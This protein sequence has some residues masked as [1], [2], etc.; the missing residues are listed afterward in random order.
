MESV[1]TIQRISYAFAGRVVAVRVSGN[2]DPAEDGLYYLHNDQLGS[3]RMIS[4]PAGQEADGPIDYY[5]F[6]EY[7]FAPETDL[8]DRGFTGHRH[9]NMT[10]NDLG[11]IYM[12]ARYYVP[13]IGRFASADTIVPDP[14]NPQSFNRY[15]YSLNNPIYYTDPSG[16][17]QGHYDTQTG[18]ATADQEC[19]D[20]VYQEFC[21]GGSTAICAGYN[22]RLVVLPEHG[23]PNLLFFVTPYTKDELVTLRDA[24]ADAINALN[25]AGYDG[26]ALTEAIRFSH[27][28]C[29]GKSCT[30]SSHYIMLKNVTKQTIW[31]E[32]GHA[33]S[34][35]NDHMP[36]DSYWLFANIL[37]TAF[38]DSPAPY[39]LGNF[40]F[41]EYCT[42]EYPWWLRSYTGD[43]PEYWADGFSAWVYYQ[44]NGRLPG[45]SWIRDG[46]KPSWT[47]ILGAVEYSLS[48][49][50]GN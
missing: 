19:W 41:R 4:D 8:T 36:Q 3:V 28:S 39:Q 21:A 26:F 38:P 7:R 50:F 23:D 45:T 2:L 27:E 34:F 15:S 46:Y 12:N 24:L 18:Q 17:C 1:Y 48:V 6:G 14:A 9:N 43:H 37:S 30:W 31:H 20:F 5:P 32:L 10:A 22:E 25:G 16:H 44:A 11:L 47:A 33:I 35:Q 29:F 49:T 40:C 13:A 42:T